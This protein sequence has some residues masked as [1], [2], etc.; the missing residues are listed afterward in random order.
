MH[1][2]NESGLNNL[3]FFFFKSCF[4]TFIYLRKQPSLQILHEN[5][6]YHSNNLYTS[7]VKKKESFVIFYELLLKSYV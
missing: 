4:Y 6:V 3:V 7:K 5:N 2:G 1:N